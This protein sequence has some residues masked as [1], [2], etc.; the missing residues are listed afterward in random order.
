M[1]DEQKTAFA[2]S[3][4]NRAD[5]V[6]WYNIAYL[7]PGSNLPWEQ[8]GKPVTEYTW[9]EFLALPENLQDDFY[10]AFEEY[11]DEAF[12]LWF[13]TNMPTGE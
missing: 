2:E 8:T 3:F 13:L 7:K 9:E 5:F 12:E 11:G 6:K 10:E 1:T 4:E